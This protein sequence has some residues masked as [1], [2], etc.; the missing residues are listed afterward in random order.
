M[1]ILI[2]GANGFIGRHLSDHLRRS[3]E[4]ELTCVGSS[5]GAMDPATGLLSPDFSIPE[6]TEAVIYLSQSPHWRD[7]PTRYDHVLAANCGSPTRLADLA[8]RSGVRRFLFASSGTVYRPSL[9]PLAEDA[10]ANRRDWYG[11]SKLFGEE[12]LCNLADKM[13]ICCM[14]LFGVY[15]P[16]QQGRLLENLAARISA[17]LPV[18][19]D[20]NPE[21]GVDEG[22]TLSMT[23]VH[24]LCATIRA[25]LDV[26]APPLILNVASDQRANIHEIA[27]LVGEVI[28]FEPRFEPSGRVLGGHLIADVGRLQAIAPRDYIRIG[29]GIRGLARADL[30]AHG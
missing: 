4:A 11:L 1:K 5:T 29:D 9:S 2:F 25:L 3:G 19:L 18:T 30:L 6:G 23:H 10:P 26:E 13:Q 28:Q 16:A 20:A 17:G 22:L 8:A 21:S 15:G 12:A 14:R 24:D 7:G 27:S